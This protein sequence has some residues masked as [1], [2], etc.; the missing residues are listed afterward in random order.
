MARIA[1]TLALGAG[2][3]WGTE[4]YVVK[5]FQGKFPGSIADAKV[6]F[7]NPDPGGM[8]NPSYR[9]V[10]SGST[11]HVEV[12]NI[13]LNN[14]TPELFEELVKFFF[15]FHDPTTKDRQGN[16]VGTQYS[17]VIFCTDTEQK[18]IANKLMQDLQEAM[19]KKKVTSFSQSTI[20]T[21][22]VDYTV[23]YPAEDEH[24]EYLFK[25]PSGYCNH[26]FRFREWPEL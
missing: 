11:G 19:N 12:L 10:C 8:K 23:F 14:A 25:N 1:S 4:K 21:S 6:G 17:S 7:M 5:D 18:K 3:Y 22:V 20:H 15:M 13:E 2:C 16:D 26:R 24:Q 9:Q